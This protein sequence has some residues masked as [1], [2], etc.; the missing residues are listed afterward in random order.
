MSP[1]L[2]GKAGTGW[3]PPAP[4]HRTRESSAQL[5]FKLGKPLT[6]KWCGQEQ[7]KFV[8]LLPL[9]LI[10][11]KR[12]NEP[13]ELNSCQRGKME[14]PWWDEDASRGVSIPLLPSQKVFQR[15]METE[16]R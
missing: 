5:Q 9:S 7:E 10:A 15:C 1:R 8:V 3:A 14:R 6:V 11:C 13:K 12:Q 2:P 4:L 16:N